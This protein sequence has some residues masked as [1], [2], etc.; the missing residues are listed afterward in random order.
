M[1][2]RALLY[3]DSNTFGTMPMETL[4]SDGIYPKGERWGDHLAAGLGAVPW[5]RWI[6][7]HG[8]LAAAS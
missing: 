6:A 2:K 5:A 1:T 4:A 7:D 3:G 8:L